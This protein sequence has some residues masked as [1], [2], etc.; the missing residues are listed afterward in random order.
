MT[1]C[2]AIYLN[3]LRINYYNESESKNLQELRAHVLPLHD[4]YEFKIEMNAKSLREQYDAATGWTRRYIITINRHLVLL[5]RLSL[6]FIPFLLPSVRPLAPFARLPSF[7]PSFRLC[8][9]RHSR[10]SSL[11]KRDFYTATQAKDKLSYLYTLNLRPRA[12]RHC[13]QISPPPPAR[14]IPS[15]LDASLRGGTRYFHGKLI[16][17]RSCPCET[18]N[19]E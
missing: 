14:L 15:N 1:N 7:S 3:A 4:V 2:T 8:E 6:S 13:I 11:Y 12:D 16:F 18:R 9:P 5:V 19:L 10:G 17:S